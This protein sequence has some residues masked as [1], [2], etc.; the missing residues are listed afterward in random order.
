MPPYVL[1][2]TGLAGCCA[3]AAW[4][5]KRPTS[6]NAVVIATERMNALTQTSQLASNE[7]M[8][9]ITAERGDLTQSSQRAGHRGH[10]E[11]LDA[12]K[13]WLAVSWVRIGC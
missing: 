11:Q 9:G 8:H 4:A 1:G 12:W 2:S 10:G 5:N 3:V 6:M 13:G 7:T